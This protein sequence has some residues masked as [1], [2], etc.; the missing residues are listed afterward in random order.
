MFTTV[1]RCRRLMPGSTGLGEPRKSEE[2]RFEHGAHLVVLA[3]LN[4]GQ[5]AVPGVVDEDV[6]AA[7]RRFGPSNRF[8]HLCRVG[9][10]ELESESLA[11]AAEHQVLNLPGIA[12]GH[13]H[14]IPAI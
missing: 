8:G 13:D 12:G 11:I 14:P 10:I 7:K 4:A 5:V 1:P 2:I 9:Y 6:D 3:F